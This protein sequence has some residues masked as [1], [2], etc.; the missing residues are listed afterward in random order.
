MPIHSPHKTVKCL[1]LAV[2]ALV[3]AAG[4]RAQIITFD[5]LPEGKAV[6]KNSLPLFI[7]YNGQDLVLIQRQGRLKNRLE[8]VRYT[9]DLKEQRRTVVS[10]GGTPEC[11]GGYINGDHIDL[12]QAEHNA[13][14]MH[15]YRD[16]RNLQTL[17]PDST[18]LTLFRR[19]GTQGDAFLFDIA[20]SPNG[21]LLACVAVADRMAQGTETTVGLYNHQ[22]EEYWIQTTSRTTPTGVAVTDEGDVILYTLAEDGRCLFT[23]FDG[24]RI[25]DISFKIPE[26]PLV[27]ERTLLRYGDGNILLA[28]AVRQENHVLMPIGTNIDRIDIHCYNI[29]K[30]TLNT[31]RRPFTQHE[32]N[33]LTNQ[34]EDTRL[35]RLWV[36]FGRI[37]QTLQDTSGA[38][39]M[40]DQKWNI[41][42]NDV[43]TGVQ[44]MG[45]MVMRVD[46][47]GNILWGT[48]KRMT[49]STSWNRRELIDYRWL[50]T[51][52]GIM[53]SWMDHADNSAYP[54]AKPVKLFEPYTHPAALNVWTLSPDGKEDWSFIELK[55]HALAGST[56]SLA[57]PGEYVVL[58]TT[59]WKSQLTE[60][61]IENQ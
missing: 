52:D 32:V 60:I 4:A 22:L 24:E 54:P 20:V 17:Q 10:E 14:G 56:H 6:V 44:R 18:P 49:S 55:R 39:L 43:T 27:V 45:M 30:Q 15:I 47:N 53:L 1:I 40:I 3:S 35:N 23:L 13:D 8:L 57:T 16:R 31:I 42:T 51:P 50:P 11:Y 29:R 21:K 28:D 36:Q 48:A 58:L 26:G 7:G 5:Q 46:R 59:G 37:C 38:Y 41:A 19:T 2:A 33:R 34:K 25:Q 61:K 9:G 12:L